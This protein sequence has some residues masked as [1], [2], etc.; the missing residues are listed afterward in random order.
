M[1]NNINEINNNLINRYDPNHKRESFEKEKKR[2]KVISINENLDNQI[3]NVNDSP[4]NNLG[5]LKNEKYKIKSFNREFND[6]SNNLKEEYII[7]SIN[8]QFNDNSNDEYIINSIN[9]DS[10]DNNI[11]ND[12]K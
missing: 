5:D 4:N 9:E 3:I 11:L 7:K 6:K 10:N 12:K 1:Q 8:G 2:F